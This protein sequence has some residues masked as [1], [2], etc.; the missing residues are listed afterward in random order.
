MKISISK[1]KYIKNNT[2]LENFALF[3]C[4]MTLYRLKL[5]NGE[6]SIKANIDSI[7]GTTIPIYG[8]HK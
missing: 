8:E 2:T 3:N 5:S 4:M 6:F 1:I 7:K